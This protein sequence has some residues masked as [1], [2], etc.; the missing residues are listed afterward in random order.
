MSRTPA[1]T[2][3]NNKRTLS[4]ANSRRKMV[5]TWA[6]NSNRA[7]SS[8]SAESSSLSAK[9][10]SMEKSPLRPVK[11]RPEFTPADTSWNTTLTLR[12]KLKTVKRPK[13]KKNLNA[14]SA[15]NK[16]KM[17]KTSCSTLVSAWVH[18]VPSTWSAWPS[19][20]TSRSKNK[21]SAGPNITISKSLSAKFA[22]PSCQWSLKST[23]TTKNSSQLKNPKETT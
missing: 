23:A 11:T 5:N 20:F 7:R 22:K 13:T 17:D 9:P 19:G 6:T 12:K 8:N 14:K 4:C 3:L 18:V 1:K 21:S 10:A 2:K 15:W 16:L